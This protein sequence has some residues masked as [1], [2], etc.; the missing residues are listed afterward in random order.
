VQTLDLTDRNVQ[1]DI[2][3]RLAFTFATAKKAEEDAAR[4]EFQRLLVQSPRT[5]MPQ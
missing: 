4:V 5:E 3:K 2:A 1:I